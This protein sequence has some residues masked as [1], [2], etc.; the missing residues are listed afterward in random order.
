MLTPKYQLVS[1]FDNKKQLSKANVI[2]YLYIYIYI[3]EV[4]KKKK[5]LQIECFFL[6]GEGGGG[7]LFSLKLR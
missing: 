7:V 5:F 4:A 2:G 6:G 3:I 1:W